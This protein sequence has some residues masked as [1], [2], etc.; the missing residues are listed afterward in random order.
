[1][2]NPLPM[3][4][5]AYPELVNLNKDIAAANDGQL[6]LLIAE[7]NTDKVNFLSFRLMGS[8]TVDSKYVLKLIYLALFFIGG[9]NIA[10]ARDDT[11]ALSFDQPDC[12]LIYKISDKNVCKSVETIES[13]TKNYTVKRENIKSDSTEGG[14]IER[15]NSGSN[16][17]I[18]KVIFFGEMGKR[19]IKYYFNGKANPIFSLDATVNYDRPM[20]IS[21][22]KIESIEKSQL[23][24]D[25]STLLFSMPEQKNLVSDKKINYVNKIFKELVSK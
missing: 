25:D 18:V 22:K 13:E 23:I 1:M 2:G 16:I 12:S 15:Y 20:Y 7:I 21:G 14:V 11:N 6:R 17:K 10:C 3:M 4:A 9:S 5:F 19:I 24:Y 8:D